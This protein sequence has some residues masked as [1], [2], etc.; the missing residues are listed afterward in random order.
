MTPEQIAIIRRTMEEIERRPGLFAQTLYGH[1]FEQ[2]PD[3]AVLFTGDR[4]TQE[5]QLAA[6]MRMV[7]G[8]L[9]RIDRIRPALRNLGMR[10]CRYGV[11]PADYTAF[12]N[13]ML[14]TVEGLLGVRY[15]AE[16]RVAWIAFYVLVS[17]IMQG[18]REW[19]ADLDATAAASDR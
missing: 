1:L 5:D 10:H 17:D 3:A 19:R 11:T 14:A 4:K 16:V 18:N 15:T 6:M 2:K 9:D 12:G 7:I 13:A 8:T